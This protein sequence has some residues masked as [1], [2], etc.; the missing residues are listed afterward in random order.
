M[1]SNPLKWQIPGFPGY[2]A[3]EAGE[4][5]SHQ[6]GQPRVL[7]P[8][9]RKE[10]GRKRY[11]LRAGDGRYVRKYGSYFVL[12]AVRGPKPDGVEACHNDGDC[13]N[14]APDNLRWDTPVANKGDMLR[15]GTRAM[16][17]NHPKAKLRDVDIVEILNLR[18]AG[19]SLRAI[20]D[21]YGVTEQRVYQICKKGAR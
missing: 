4:I 2:F 9:L 5:V 14:D 20:G 16:G 3:T 1:V 15:H 19:L 12:L 10:D 18:R 6:K 11:T 7:K 17:E 8:D 13:T 21:S